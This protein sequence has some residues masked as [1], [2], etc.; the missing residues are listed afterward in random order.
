MISTHIKTKISFFI[1]LLSIASYSQAV[2]NDNFNP[3]NYLGLN[4]V[5]SSMKF[6]KDYGSNIFSNKMAPGLNFFVGHMFNDN[7]GAEI[8]YEVNKDMKRTETITSGNIVTGGFLDP[9]HVDWF[10]YKTLVEQH[11]L[12]LG[13]IAKSNFFDDKNFVSLMLGISSS[14]IKA[15]YNI[16]KS[17][18]G[19]EDTT[20]TFAR[21]KLVPI[22]RVSVERK[23]NEKFGLQ[24]LVGWK[25]TSKF[26]LKSEENSIS[27]QEVRLKDT[28]SFGV[29]FSYYI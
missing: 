19:T 29:G 10:S 23:F 24:A 16:F 20:R 2:S 28:F 6:K 4:A 8:G 18:A 25:N 7:W 22:I 5:C 3:S 15:K 13:G 1:S 26:K 21:N 12:Y 9:L 14:D 27:T 17:E 11:H